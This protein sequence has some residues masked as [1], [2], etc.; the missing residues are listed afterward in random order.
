MFASIPWFFFCQRMIVV[1][2]VDERSSFSVSNSRVS[3]KLVTSSQSNIRLFCH[4]LRGRN[5][6]SAPTRYIYGAGVA[7]DRRRPARLRRELAAVPT[8]AIR[9]RLRN[10]SVAVASSCF[11]H[12][13]LQLHCSE[14]RPSYCCG[15]GTSAQSE[16][17]SFSREIFYCVP[18]KLILKN[19]YHHGSLFFYL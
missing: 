13:Q 14:H 1:F 15:E 9:A 6:H 19:T 10:S 16:S 12:A 3:I 11:Y 8:P 4:R 18:K 5:V 17:S 2:F 7:E